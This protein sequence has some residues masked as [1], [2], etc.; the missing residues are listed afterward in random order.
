MNIR[1]AKALSQ[2]AL[3]QIWFGGGYITEIDYK[4]SSYIVWN[5]L[6]HCLT[7]KGHER[8]EN[9]QRKWEALKPPGTGDRM[10]RYGPMGSTI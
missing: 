1:D 3:Q 9:L 2:S 8:I 5:S 6:G 4:G 7:C 10:R